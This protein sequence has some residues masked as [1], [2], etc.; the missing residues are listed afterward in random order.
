MAT[1]A[2]IWSYVK[3]Y[4][5]YAAL[6]LAVIFG[7]LLFKK[8]QIDF[9]DALKKIQEAHEEEIR[10]IQEARE[11]ER[12]QHEANLKRLQDT[13]DAV[14]KQYD[15]AKKDLDTKKKKEIEDLVK[16]F[17]DNP[18]ELAKKL[19]EATGFVIVLPS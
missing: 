6:L 17:G 7:Y 3:K 16:Q 9:A 11:E 5:S 4:W 1:L 12:R 18:D 19:S 15:D 2:V 13:L 14:Q 10:K 8:E